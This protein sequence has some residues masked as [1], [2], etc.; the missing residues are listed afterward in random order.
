M[1]IEVTEEFKIIQIFV[2]GVTTMGLGDNGKLYKWN[3]EQR[4][5]YEA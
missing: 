5:W 4:K 1:K 3:V 2:Q